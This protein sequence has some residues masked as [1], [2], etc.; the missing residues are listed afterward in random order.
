MTQ[1]A[2]CATCR[3]GIELVRANDGHHHWQ[4]L[5]AQPDPQHT[6]QPDEVPA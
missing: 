2:T 1:R 4:H 5:I 3:L 6:P